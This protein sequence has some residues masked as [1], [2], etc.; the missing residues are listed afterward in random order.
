V[1][2]IERKKSTANS[3]KFDSSNVKCLTNQTIV[4]SV[5]DHRYPATGV[6]RIVVRASVH[7]RTQ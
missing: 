5:F 2:V 6:P 3:F 1:V 4:L 7:A